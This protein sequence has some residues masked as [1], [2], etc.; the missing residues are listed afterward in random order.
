VNNRR[1]WSLELDNGLLVKLGSS[2]VDLRLSRFVRFYPQLVS[3]EEG[4]LKLVDLRYT[5]VS[6]SNA[7]RFRRKAPSWMLVKTAV[8]TG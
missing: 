8:V 1:A 4:E 3:P 6:Q 5:T 7:N 2:N